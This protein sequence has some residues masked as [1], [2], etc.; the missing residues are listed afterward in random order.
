MIL[1]L[2]QECFLSIQTRSYLFNRRIRLEE[3]GAVAAWICFDFAEVGSA[4]DWRS[5]LMIPAD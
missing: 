5:K 3:D 4:R 1:L 2:E